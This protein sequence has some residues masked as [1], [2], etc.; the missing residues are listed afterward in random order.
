[1]RLRWTLQAAEDLEAIKKF[2]ERD[3][4]TY[5]RQV[6]ELVS[7][8]SAMARQSQSGEHRKAGRATP[9]TGAA[10]HAKITMYF[11]LPSAHDFRMEC[12]H[13]MRGQAARG[14]Y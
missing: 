6:A 13:G 3:S 7:T 8:R 2:I 5:A 14:R 9:L 10:Q 11:T 4:P 1:M 12:E